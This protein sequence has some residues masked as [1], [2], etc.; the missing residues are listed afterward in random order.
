MT[1]KRILFDKF[2]FPI[3]KGL[4]YLVNE[5]LPDT[6]FLLINDPH[7]SFSIMIEK[8][9]PI[10]T[11]P[12]GSERD[13]CLLE[14]KRKDRTIKFFCPEKH[15][16]LDTVVWYFCV[17]LPDGEGTVHSLPGQVR[18]TFDTPCALAAKPK[19]L[20]VLETVALATTI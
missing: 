12:E 8:G 13:Y 2:E 9:F 10:F 11:V 19:F 4:E 6:D 16:N 1:K 5:N 18:V 14:L 7:D 15:K 17:E 3:G 20:E